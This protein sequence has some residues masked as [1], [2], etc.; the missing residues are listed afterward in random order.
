MWKLCE[1][2]CGEPAPI[3]TKSRGAERTPKGE[4]QRF[5]RGHAVINRRFAK[6]YYLPQL[7]DFDIGW[8]VGIYEGEG[9]VGFRSRR[10]KYGTTIQVSVQL[11]STDK[12]TIDRLHTLIPGS[13][14]CIE[15]KPT[16]AGKLVYR[17]AI[18][19]ITLAKRFLLLIQPHLSVRRQDQIDKA[20]KQQTH[21][22]H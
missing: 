17:W 18:T 8:L 9:S 1:C 20:L 15:N 10:G 16:K 4:Y 3:A 6:E 11:C 21:T 12:D 7:T 19:K 2:G 5:I 14:K 22:I 13:T